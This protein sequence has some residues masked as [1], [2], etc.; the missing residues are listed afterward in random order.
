MYGEDYVELCQRQGRFEERDSSEEE[1]EKAK[2]EKGKEEE[3]VVEQIR[4]WDVVPVVSSFQFWQRV[5]LVFEILRPR[6][7]FT[8][9]LLF[10]LFLL[11]EC[12]KKGEVIFVNDEGKITKRQEEN[13][14]EKSLEKDWL[15][16]GSFASLGYS[17]K[18]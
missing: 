4:R 17:Q 7:F 14:Q 1:K 13:Y 16:F 10:L 11:L 9:L 5:G 12:F 18:Q 3:F 6:R 2:N 15:E 8:L